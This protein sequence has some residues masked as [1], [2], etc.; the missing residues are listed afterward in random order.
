MTSIVTESV[1]E[2]EKGIQR[3]RKDKRVKKYLEQKR[4]KEKERL[5]D[6]RTCACLGYNMALKDGADRDLLDFLHR[7]HQWA[8]DGLTNYDPAA[9]VQLGYEVPASVFQRALFPTAQTPT[10]QVIP[11]HLHTRVYTDNRTRKAARGARPE[12]G[13]PACNDRHAKVA[14][15]GRLTKPTPNQPRD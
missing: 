3:Q 10:V 7:E 13:E 14:P 4:P 8:V 11:C 9:L 2:G 5:Y 12:A 1:Q 6:Y 15:Q